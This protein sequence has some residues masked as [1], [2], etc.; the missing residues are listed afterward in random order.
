MSGKLN[1]ESVAYA[2]GGIIEDSVDAELL[3]GV[4]NILLDCLVEASV[5]DRRDPGFGRARRFVFSLLEVSTADSSCV[6]TIELC[7][8]CREVED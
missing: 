6:G 1:T 3:P 5:L 4:S 8:E 2:F 7:S